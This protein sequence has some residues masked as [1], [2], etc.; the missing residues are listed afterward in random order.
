MHE[1]S[2]IQL[3]MNTNKDNLSIEELVV[4]QDLG[5]TLRMKL[6]IGLAELFK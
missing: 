2:S 4:G 1:R 6:I 3:L 5:E